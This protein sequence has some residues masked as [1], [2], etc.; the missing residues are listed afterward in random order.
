MSWKDALWQVWVKLVL[1]FWRRLW[2]FVKVFSLFC[3]YIPLEKG[4]A[5]DFNKLELP[6]S[7]E[8][9]CQVKLILTYWFWRRRFLYMKFFTIF[10]LFRNY[11]PWNRKESFIWINLNSL[12]PR[13]FVPSLVEIGTVVL[14]K[15]RKIW[16]VYVNDDN[17]DRKWTKAYLIFGS[18][19]LKICFIT[20]IYYLLHSMLLYS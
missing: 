12:P 14:E 20:F 15:K 16:K 10:S 8:T 9:L 3:N 7:K 2:K 17:D 1:W 11:L 18:G 4:L 13:I 19:E 5:I 6:S